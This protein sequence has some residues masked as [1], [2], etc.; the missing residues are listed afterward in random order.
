MPRY[1]IVVLLLAVLALVAIVAAMV[2]EGIDATPFGTHGWIALTIGVVLS[3]GVGGGLMA[4]LFFSSRSGHDERAT[5]Y[6]D[7]DDPKRRR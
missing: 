5:S 4:L 7:T 6:R 2:W 3:F 1:V